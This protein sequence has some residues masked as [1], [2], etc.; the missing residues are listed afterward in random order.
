M[1]TV[2]KEPLYNEKA[3]AGKMFNRIYK[4]YDLLNHVL[5]MRLDVRWRKLVAQRIQEHSG[6]NKKKVLDIAMGTGDLAISVQKR[7]SGHQF[8]C[9]DIAENMMLLAKEKMQKRRIK[10]VEFVLGDAAELTLDDAGFDFIT[11]GFGVRNFPELDRSM[12]ECRRVLKQGGRMYILE[13]GW[14]H[15]KVFGWL[16]KIFSRTIIPFLGWIIAGDRAAYEYLR[17][18]I[19]SFPYG[20]EFEARLRGAGFTEI[21]STPLAGGIVYLY[22][23]A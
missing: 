4:R 5:T 20:A 6:K 18:T 8:V 16:Y 15:N 10:D 17:T 1:T 12:K 9:L 19:R 3:A 22:E 23:A 21:S 2:E 7:N 13:F 11:I 14:P